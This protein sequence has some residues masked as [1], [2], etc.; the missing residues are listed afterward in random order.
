MRFALLV[1]RAVYQIQ[2]RVGM[3]PAEAALGSMKTWKSI[4]RPQAAFVKRMSVL[5]FCH[6]LLK[7]NDDI[8]PKECPVRLIMFSEK[9]LYRIIGRWF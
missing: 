8:F 4:C 9:L 6:F 5:R 2:G 7:V 1:S 3:F